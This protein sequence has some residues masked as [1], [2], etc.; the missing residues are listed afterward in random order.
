MIHFSNTKDRVCKPDMQSYLFITLILEN[1]VSLKILS[2]F[3][4]SIHW[5]LCHWKAYRLSLFLLCCITCTCSLSR[6]ISCSLFAKRPLNR[7]TSAWAASTCWP[8]SLAPLWSLKIQLIFWW[9]I[10]QLLFILELDLPLI[11]CIKVLPSTLPCIHLS[12]SFQKSPNF[13]FSCS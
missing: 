4:K 12:S 6:W 5:A 10:F 8:I 1:Q 7:W 3:P 11:F 2:N 13:S 9:K